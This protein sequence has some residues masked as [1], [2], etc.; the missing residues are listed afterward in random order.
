MS[1]KKQTVKNRLRAVWL[2]LAWVAGAA[3]AEQSWSLLTSVSYNNGDYIY[4][5]TIENYYFNL[6]VRYRAA[7]WTVS[8]T[9]P[10][11]TQ[12]DN[13]G[14]VSG[15]N[16][17]TNS[18]VGDLYVFGERALWKSYRKRSIVSLFGQL[19]VPHGLSTVNFSSQVMDAGIGINFRRSLGNYSIFSDIGY[20][21]LG[22]P[23]GLE[24][25]DPLS[26][27]LGMGRFFLRRLI[28]TSVYYKSYTQILNGIMPPKQL[29]L[30]ISA[31]LTNQTN[32]SLYTSV[33]LSESS[34]DY[35]I[36]FGLTRGL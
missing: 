22:D 27:G 23:E 12:Q 35:G 33:G 25:S 4:D 16:T 17:V 26:Y 8:A 36:S 34:P 1:S 31:K 19:K 13:V 6:G 20:L 5:E 32:L 14:L 15:G 2:I 11:L 3:Q 10:F 30:G 21:S 28:S 24:Y 29:S 9:L 7:K 18:G